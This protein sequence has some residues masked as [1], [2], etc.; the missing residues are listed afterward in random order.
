[1]GRPEEC[2]ELLKQ[3]L[4]PS[5]ISNKLGI[6]ESSA[7]GYC[8]RAVAQ[9]PILRTQALKAIDAHFDG[10]FETML[11]EQEDIATRQLTRRLNAAGFTVSSRD[12]D[13]YRS[14]RGSLID[15]GLMYDLI[16]E[17]EL[18]LHRTIKEV[19]I[20]EHGPA[21]DDW[22]RKG[23]PQNVRV[24]CVSRR[25]Q[26]SERP[27]DPYSYTTFVNLVEIMEKKWALLAR[28]RPQEFGNDKSDLLRMLRRLNSLRNRI[29]HPV[30]CRPLTPADFDVA[31]AL[32]KKFVPGGFTIR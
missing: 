20:Q 6:A 27:A 18:A 12:V 28:V 4:L 1:M 15:V 9:Y 5:A 2:A 26:D 22:W 7:I 10:T 14:L 29:M 17:I 24:E 30:R 32:Y 25:E 8:Q 21:Y 3:G 13:F 19:L 11:E 31:R 23:M 16:A